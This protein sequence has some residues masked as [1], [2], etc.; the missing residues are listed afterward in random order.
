[1]NSNYI[2]RTILNGIEYLV[3]LYT[4]KVTG[5][6]ESRFIPNQDNKLKL[7]NL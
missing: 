2:H 5:E 4:D 3:L 1:M 7:I 6:P